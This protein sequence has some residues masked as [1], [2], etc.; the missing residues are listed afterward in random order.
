MQLV[1]GHYARIKHLL[2]FCFCEKVSLVRIIRGGKYDTSF[3]DCEATDITAQGDNGQCPLRQRLEIRLGRNA[4]VVLEVEL[5]RGH[6][7]DVG[8]VGSGSV[9]AIRKRIG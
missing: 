5:V 9:E 3:E 2:H 7:E 1:P 8:A 4:A 6:F